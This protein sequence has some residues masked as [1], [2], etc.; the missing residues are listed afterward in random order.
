MR[1]IYRYG[2]FGARFAAGFAFGAGLG[3]GR[4]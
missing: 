2:F 1:E 3:F 4:G